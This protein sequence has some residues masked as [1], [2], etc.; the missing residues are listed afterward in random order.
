VA[1]V[2]KQLQEGGFLLKP[3]STDMGLRPMDGA[4]AADA[5]RASANLGSNVAM[6]AVLASILQGEPQPLPDSQIV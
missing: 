3:L 4:T 6:D 2:L 1:E 5:E